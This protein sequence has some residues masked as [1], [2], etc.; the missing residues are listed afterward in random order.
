[1]K[2]SAARSNVTVLPPLAIPATCDIVYSHNAND[3]AII[4]DNFL[5]S[6]KPPCHIGFDLEWP[7]TFE[8]GKESKTAVIQFCNNPSEACYILHVSCMPTI[9]NQLVQIIERTD[10]IKVGVNI[11]GDLF[12]LCRDF[13]VKFPDQGFIDL[14]VLANTAMNL[15]DKWSLAGLIKFLF[16]RKLPKDDHI[17][18]GSWQ[19]YPLNEQQLN[20]AA[21]DAIA[22]I[23][24]YNQIVHQTSTQ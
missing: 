24:V 4:C 21:L 22:S 5:N 7:V 11:Q 12:K 14:G 18:K 23:K 3:C 1:M 13:D 15:N 10:I 8:S 9:P 6:L 16:H 19:V 17:R 20:Y 2:K